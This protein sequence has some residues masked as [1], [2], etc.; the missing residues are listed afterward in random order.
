MHAARA[1]RRSRGAERPRPLDRRRV[2][3]L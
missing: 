1:P 3:G 2:T